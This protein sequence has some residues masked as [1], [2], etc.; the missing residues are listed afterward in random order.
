MLKKNMSKVFLSFIIPAYNSERYIEPCLDSIINQTCDDYEIVIIND[1]STDRTSDIIDKY[2]KEYPEKTIRVYMQQNQGISSARNNGIDKA[3]GE[4]ITFVDH[5]DWIEKNYVQKVK[6]KLQSE[7]S[8]ML[9]FG[10]NTID[11]NDN[12]IHTLPVAKDKKWARWGVCTVW[13]IVAKRD[14]FVRNEIYFP[15]NLFN[16]DIPVAINLSFYSQKF[17]TL[18]EILYHYRVYIGNT[19]SKIHQKYESSPESRRNVF[20]VFSDIITKL[21]KQDEKDLVIYNAI[22]FYYGLLFVYF[23]YNTKEELLDEYEKY[24][25][26]LV[27]FFPN[28]KRA[29]IHLFKPKGEPFMKRFA[30]WVAMIFDR[31]GI[32]KILLLIVNKKI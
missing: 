5:D 3:Q 6:N 11:E 28:Y 29:K 27:E 16:E 4:Y 19:C 15:E 12:I 13:L 30:V 7:N 9:V 2:I 8:D 25:K 21:D 17:T 10:Y 23:K 20:R 24:T 22:K 26:A 14:L 1:G 18:N 32:F 31:M